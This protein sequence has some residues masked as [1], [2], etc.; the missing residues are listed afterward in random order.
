MA[1]LMF[2]MKL[3]KLKNIDTSAINLIII[4]L[5]KLTIEIYHWL[6]SLIKS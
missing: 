1:I 3:K 2:S 4:K 5:S 6:M